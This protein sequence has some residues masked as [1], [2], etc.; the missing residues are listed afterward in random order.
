MPA[1]VYKECASYISE[2]LTHVYNASLNQGEYP[3]IYKLEITTPVPKIQ[4]VEKM[5]QM[6]NISGL[7]TADKIFEKLLSEMIICDMTKKADPSQYGNQTET[8]IQHYLIKIIHQIHSALDNNARRDIFPVVANMIDWN[9]AFVRQCPILGVKSFQ[10]NGVRKSLIPLIIS[11]FQERHQSV[12]WRGVNTSPRQIN[13]G[14]PQ[15]ATLGILEFLSQTNNSA[16]CVGSSERF[17]FVDDLT[18]LEIVNLLTIGMTSF[19]IKHQVP[20]DIAEDNQFIP[21]EHLKSQDYLNKINSWTKE[22]K[23]M[24]NQTKTKTMIF[25]HTNKY[26]FRTRLELNKYILETVEETK[27]LGTIITN[28]LKWDKNT[29]RIIKRS[30]ARMDILR[31]LSEYQPPVSDMKQ[32]YITFV[33]SLLEQSSNVWH[34]SLTQQNEID[35][36]RVQKIALKIILKD[37]YTSYLNALNI[38]EL[39]TLKDRREHMMLRFA[40]K[41][42][43]NP[44]MKNLFPPNQSSHTM[45][46]RDHE[47]FQVFHANTKRLQ[48]SPIIYMQNLL[49]NEIK[50]RQQEAQMWTI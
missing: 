42:L 24:I 38:L 21:P 37:K 30:Y 48:D 45:N 50:R 17:K 5:S 8:S 15:G 36:E 1:K 29:D 31:K 43:K 26:Q 41:C 10:E 44:K 25:Y 6:R 2:P 16:D 3:M 47:H 20:N 23:M 27:L 28:D 14:G 39:D 7:L 46:T 32:V 12:K 40:Q 4:P 49:N 19:N 34:S 18:I 35:L 11:Y 13:G 22:H 33:G 9:Q